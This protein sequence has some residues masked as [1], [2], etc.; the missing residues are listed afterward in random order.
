MAYWVHGRDVKTGKPDSML[1]TANSPDEAREQA[2]VQGL[3]AET[4]Q[5]E[6]NPN[7][8]T[9]PLPLIRLPKI[10]RLR[11]K[12]IGLILFI[13][14]FIVAQI[15]WANDSRAYR[16]GYFEGFS[17]QI[18]AFS[19]LAWGFGCLFQSRTWKSF[20]LGCAIGML[21]VFSVVATAFISI[22]LTSSH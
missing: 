19:F 15:M 6:A 9:I 1:T 21:M 16:L 8:D 5:L 13:A 17:C 2:E 18:F 22:V 14:G 11:F 20:K 12:W 10:F 4:I 3:I 7:T